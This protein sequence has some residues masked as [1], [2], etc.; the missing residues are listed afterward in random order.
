MEAHAAGATL[1]GSR[2]TRRALVRGATG[3][4][5]GAGALSLAACGAGGDSTAGGAG[6]P[7]K[8]VQ[9]RI[10]FWG[11]G[12]SPMLETFAKEFNEQ[13]PGARVEYVPGRNW[14]DMFEKLYAA[15]AGDSGP[16]VVRVKEYN[17]IDL[18]ANKSLQSLDPFVKADKA[19]KPDQ[20][21]P[22]QWKTANFDGAQYGL[23]FFNSIHVLLW[24]KP[25]FQ[26]AGLPPDRAPQ[27][28]PELR[29]AV[30]RTAKPEQNQWG[31]KLFDYGTRE[32]IL[33]WW[34]R[35]AWTNGGRLFDKDATRVTVN[36]EPCVEA[37]QLFTDMLYKD[38]SAA[39]P[40]RNAEAVP[41]SGNVGLWETGAYGMVDMNKLAPSI[42]YGVAELPWAKQKLALVYQDNLIMTR[43]GKNK[44]GG[45]ALMR[46]ATEPEQDYRWALDGGALPSRKE[47]FKRAPFDGSDKNWKVFVDAFNNP[48]SKG[49]PVVIKWEEFALTITEELDAAFKNQKPPKQALDEA[50]RKAT[51]FVQ[52]NNSTRLT[53]HL[54]KDK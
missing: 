16:E 25:L 4:A 53:K 47:N 11:P 9:G 3:V 36:S 12:A 34:L 44:E 23:P 8:P 30:R 31:F 17:A 49:K 6:A 48:T 38:R 10:E 2:G 52:E 41:T 26:Q 39:P 35:F 43:S 37:L 54:L 14:V 51:Q 18:G 7:Q 24:N 32:A 15:I 40:E 20:F 5:V 21:T 28:W 42:P 46:Y 45:W 1:G 29:E 27:S 33:V 50:A 13:N 22:E 19:F